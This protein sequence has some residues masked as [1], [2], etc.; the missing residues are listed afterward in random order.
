M[1]LLR[2]LQNLG[3]LVTKFTSMKTSAFI[4]IF[5]CLFAHTH[6]SDPAQ[7]KL[8]LQ[9]LVKEREERFGEYSRA[10]AARTGLFGNKT[11][12]DL[13]SQVDVLT[14]IIKTDNRIISTLEVFLDYRSFQKT[15]MTY[16]QADLDQKNQRLNELTTVL[17]KKLSTAEASKKALEI[18][19]KWAKLLNYFLVLLLLVF[20]YFYWKQRRQYKHHTS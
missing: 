4:V 2:C 8:L 18:R 9:K 11:K 20:A 19:I 3:N 16:S 13:K 5:F 15:E 6:G 7:E 1:V 10:A 14:T 12:N 17:S